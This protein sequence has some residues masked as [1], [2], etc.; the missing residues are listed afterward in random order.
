MSKLCHSFLTWFWRCFVSLIKF[1]YWSEFHFNIITGSAVMTIFFI[2]DWPEIRKSE[3]LPSEFWPI[4]EDWGKLE[5]QSLARMSQMLLNAAKCHS[6]SLYS[7]WVIK[8]KSTRGEGVKLPP[9]NRDGLKANINSLK[10]WDNSKSRSLL[11][12]LR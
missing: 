10:W 5:I 1:S 2:N 11:S 7:F 8:G 4:S 12:S 9:P 3:I 6:Y